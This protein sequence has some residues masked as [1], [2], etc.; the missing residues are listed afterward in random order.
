MV[1]DN[2]MAENVFTHTIQIPHEDTNGDF[3]VT[4]ADYYLSDGPYSVIYTIE[5]DAGNISDYSTGLD[6]VIDITATDVSAVAIDLNDAFDSGR[7]NGDD[8]SSTQTQISRSFLYCDSHA[9]DP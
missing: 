5:D 4:D 7:D 3:V 6:I 1:E 8:V 9:S 2:R